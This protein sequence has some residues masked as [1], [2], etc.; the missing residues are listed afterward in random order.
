MK[1]LTGLGNVFLN[2]KNVIAH[3]ILCVSGLFIV[4]IFTLYVK[5][6]SFCDF[7]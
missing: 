7:E 2:K 1:N 5:E 3:F 6:N 4:G